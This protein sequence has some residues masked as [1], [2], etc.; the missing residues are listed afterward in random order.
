MLSSIGAITNEKQKLRT[1]AKIKSLE[2]RDKNIA[3]I[4]EKFA[5]VHKEERK[6]KFRNEGKD[7][8]QKRNRSWG[9]PT[10]I[11]YLLIIY[12]QYQ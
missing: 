9:K 11:R 5:D 7:Q 4:T 10:D 3:Q 6:R 1:T 8:S 12:Y 2:K